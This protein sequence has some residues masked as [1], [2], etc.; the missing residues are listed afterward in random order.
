MRVRRTPIAIAIAITIGAL[1]T[2]TAVGAASPAVYEPTPPAP[3]TT[4]PTTPT[5]TNPTP[6]VPTAPTPTSPTPT[7][8]APTPSAPVPT[9]PATTPP[10]A[11]VAPAGSQIIVDEFS[12]V[13]LT[14][15]ASWTDVR[16]ETRTTSDGEQL[17]QLI[18]TAQ[19]DAFG[20]G[21]APGVAV[22]SFATAKAATELMENVGLPCTTPGTA[23]PWAAI[24]FNGLRSTETGCGTTGTGTMEVIAAVAND[25]SSSAVVVIAAPTPADYAHVTPIVMSL[26][27]APATA[28]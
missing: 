10:A 5:P 3:S 13:S 4:V 14:V 2:S 15:P 20:D 1:A 27:P 19:F 23:T 12:V 11:P 28:P 16:H 18:A 9:S 24:G 6:T 25:G 22:F 21:D 26:A 17:A 8:P 7:S